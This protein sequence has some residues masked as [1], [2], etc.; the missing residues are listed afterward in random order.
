MGRFTPPAAD[1]SLE[2]SHAGAISRMHRRAYF[3]DTGTIAA[4][5]ATRTAELTACLKPFG[6]IIETSGAYDS[7]RRAE[8]MPL[9]PIILAYLAAQPAAVGFIIAASPATAYR[10]REYGKQLLA[11]PS[12]R[13]D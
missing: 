3:A 7:S 10:S 1:Y 4:I 12:P 6:L 8:K 2:P 5:T 9:P 11:G 13:H